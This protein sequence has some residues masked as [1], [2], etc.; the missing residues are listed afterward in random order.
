MTGRLIAVSGATG[1]VGRHLVAGLVARGWRVRA[2]VRRQADLAPGVTSAVI[3]D[4]RRPAMLAEALSGVTAIVHAAGL[5]HQ[6]ADIDDAA[7]R[8]IN[9]DATAHLA[10][11]A[12]RAGVTRFVFLS[13]LR[14]QVGPAAA[15]V[16][17][18]ASPPA[19]CDAYGRS[20]LAAEEV[21]AGLDL[22]WAAL[23][24]VLVYGTGAG[25][26]LATLLALARRPWPLPFGLVRA[27]RSIVAVEGVVDAVATLL[28]APGPL[29]RPFLAA[30]ARP[31]GLAEM[32]A[33][34]RRGLGRRPGLVPVPPA[35]LRLGLAAA[36]R[37]D[38]ASRLLEPCVVD[39]TALQALGW[40]PPADPAAGLARFAAAAAS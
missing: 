40:M 25:G 39:T 21:L 5:A 12:M 20:K 22:D 35:V 11:A 16:L 17:T 10:R 30:D 24:P 19:P 6:P 2:L 33:A 27:P 34:L 31:L 37:A 9:T 8:A 18:E 1:F 3:G 26:N 36:G 13:S 28:T 23:R 38:M 7:M 29:R 14:A 15:A 4:L 32:V